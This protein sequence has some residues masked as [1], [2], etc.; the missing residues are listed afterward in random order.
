MPGGGRAGRDQSGHGRRVRRRNRRPRPVRRCPGRGRLPAPSTRR[1][2]R[3]RGVVGGGDGLRP[4]PPIRPPVRDPALA[5]HLPVKLG[6][7]VPR[8]GADVVGGT[9]HWLRLLCEHLVSMKKWRVE[10]FTTCAT[11]AATWA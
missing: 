4:G 11:S 1:R 5:G 9:E 8:Y 7:V 10:V 6:L 2:S 3:A